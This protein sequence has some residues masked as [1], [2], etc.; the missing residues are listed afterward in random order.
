MT[1]PMADSL[2]IHKIRD[3][4]PHSGPMRI[5]ERGFVCS[6]LGDQRSHETVDP[7]GASQSSRLGSPILT[8][9]SLTQFLTRAMKRTRHTPWIK[10]AWDRFHYRMSRL[11]PT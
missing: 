8:S 2:V 7:N 1:G 10:R 3:Q 11:W 5:V 4:H 6:G 9:S